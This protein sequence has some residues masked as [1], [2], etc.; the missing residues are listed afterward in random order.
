[1]RKLFQIS[2]FI[3]TVSLLCCACSTDVSIIAINAEETS[4]AE[5]QP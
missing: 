4:N 2:L 1:M 5:V 3:I